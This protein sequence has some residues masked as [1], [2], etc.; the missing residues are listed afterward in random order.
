[1]Y[2]DIHF[3]LVNT[4][5]ATP[6]FGAN[7]VTSASSDGT[8][9]LFDLV[10]GTVN[11]TLL[12]VNPQ[13]W[14]GPGSKW[15]MVYGCDTSAELHMVLAGDSEGKVHVMD[16]RVSSPVGAMQLHKAGAKVTC[17][18]FHPQSNWTVMTA[19]GSDACWSS[20]SMFPWLIKGALLSSA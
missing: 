14:G 13:G 17:I 8:V 18:D 5:H 12:D 10:T 4:L 11:S 16:P 20:I 3:A 9:K 7:A 6:W 19:G 2:R 15:S 1:M